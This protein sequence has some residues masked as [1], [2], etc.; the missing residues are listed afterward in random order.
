MTNTVPHRARR[1][2][3][4]TR[5]V[6]ISKALIGLACA[7]VLL[8]PL[9][10]L[11]AG[12]P[13]L[14]D[15]A[16]AAGDATAL[17]TL[18][19][20]IAITC[21]C[22]DFVAD[23]KKSRHRQY[24]ACAKGM[25]EAALDAGQLRSKCKMLALYPAKMSTCGRPTDPPRS[26]CVRRTAKGNVTC[27]VTKCQRADEYACPA[28]SD[29]LAAA[30]TNRD[31][32]VS[33]LD[34]GQ[35]N[36]L[37]CAAITT[38]QQTFIDDR[39]TQCYNACTQPLYIECVFGCVAASMG[40]GESV[41]AIRDACEADPAVTCDDLLA[42]SLQYCATP[43]PPPQICVDHCFGDLYCESKCVMATDCAAIANEINAICLTTEY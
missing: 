20:Q 6:R 12:V 38:L 9:A 28:Y 5:E 24:V 2:A 21:P 39:V 25:V 4:P 23:G 22:D 18:R 37:D 11:A 34:S 36:V 13:C 40:F 7:A 33:G 27:K 19:D 31:G 41:A 32:R 42:A 43:P 30:D 1:Y 10:A 14:S 35:C 26:P 15:D 29:C 17:K 8:A 3:D 16:S